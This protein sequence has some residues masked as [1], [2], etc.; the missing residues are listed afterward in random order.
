MYVGETSWLYQNIIPRGSVN[1]A[2]CGLGLLIDVSSPVGR[3][4]P[5]EMFAFQS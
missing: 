4:E 1:C 5:V 2:Y 3:E